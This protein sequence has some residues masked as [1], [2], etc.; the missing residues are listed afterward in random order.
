MVKTDQLAKNTITAIGLKPLAQKA[1]E[2]LGLKHIPKGMSR[3]EDLYPEAIPSEQF[4]STV[5]ISF[6]QADENYYPSLFFPTEHRCEANRI[7]TDLDIKVAFLTLYGTMRRLGCAVNACGP[8][9]AD[10]TVEW[11][12]KNACSRPQNTPLIME[13][14][15]L[16]R[17]SY[18]ISDCGANAQSHVAKAYRFRELNARQEQFVL[19]Y[20]EKMR[21]I[22][23]F[24]IDEAKATRV[25]GRFN[26]LFIL[27]PL[28]LANDFNLR[29]SH[30]PF[31]RYYSPKR[32]G[33]VRFAQACIDH[34]EAAR[35]PLPILFKQH[36][37]DKNDLQSAL[38]LRNPRNQ[39]ITNDQEI[40]V[41]DLFATGRCKL[42]VSV[43]SN[44][45]HEGLVWDIP[46]IALGTLLWDESRED[47]PLD[48]DLAAAERLLGQP[49]ALDAD[50]L[51][52][53]YHVI[54]NQWYLSDFQNLLIVQELIRTRSHCVPH[55]LRCRWGVDL[56]HADES[57]NTE[58]E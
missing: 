56:A 6:P 47:R 54:T 31:E 1:L 44:T 28:Q 13:H 58:T 4:D 42:V 37:S 3:G 18:Q 34:L 43:N 23:R 50:R 14:G 30:S 20:L 35:L 9:Q 16:P 36:P 12:G 49:T 46:A 17:T 25:A 15:W 45:L 27:F 8:N 53:L 2:A 51:S 40:G 26:G 57:G 21:R 39:L 55:E 33:T 32:K 5:K 24:R 11:A 7:N 19:G 48:K 10:L 22:F 52:Y 41:V 29:Y 38:K